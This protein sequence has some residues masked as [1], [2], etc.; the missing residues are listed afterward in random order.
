MNEKIVRFA[1]APGPL[2]NPLKGWC[3]YTDAGTIHQPYSLV[4]RYVSWKELEPE[5]G[6][7]RFAEWE[8]RA[9]DESKAS[10]AAGRH[11]V[12]RVY[13]DYPT[14][15]SGLPDWLR[16]KGVK[17]TL[18]SEH[19]GG[20][21]PDYD[22]PAM[23][24]GM[25]KLI[26]A[27]GRRYDRHPRVAFLQL[28]LLGFWG[29]W[30]T[31][32]HE[33]LFASAA[34]RRRVIAAYREAFPQKKLMAR[35]ADGDLGRQPWLGYHD[36]MFPEDTGDEKD[37]YFLGGLRRAGRA[38]NWRKAPIGGE[39]VPNA[40]KKW[41]SDPDYARTLRFLEEGHFSW[42]GPYSPALEA[43]PNPQFTARCAALVR[44]MGYEFALRDLRHAAIVRRT[45][46]LAITLRGVNQG[47]APFYY[48]WPVRLA[49]LDGAGRVAGQTATL[50]RTDVRA[51]LP[52]PFTVRDAA[53]FPGVTPGRYTLALG[54]CDPWTGRPAIGFANRLTR[55]GGE[56]WTALST[57]TVQ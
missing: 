5:E 38:E 30:H 52:G 22:H 48:P 12:L 11:I 10:S 26:A 47:V 57:V 50:K 21:S 32:P 44:R 1:P 28:G 53:V 16:A 4:F 35:T 54:I 8:K 25:E 46:P 42:V 19:G 27:L 37:W 41:L 14:L 7:Y 34:T 55:P 40:A 6:R 36:D 23:V 2:D 29:E 20:Q 33:K 15:P 9:W 17:V 24:A 45:E 43:P 18:Y 31:Y 13:V 51:W 49:L 56:G 3:T 39:M